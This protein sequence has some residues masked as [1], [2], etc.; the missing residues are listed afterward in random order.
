MEKYEFTSNES[1]LLFDFVNQCLS[2]MQ[3]DPVT[4]A[5]VLTDFIRFFLKKSDLDI[6]RSLYI[7]L[8]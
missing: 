7:K 2:S 3:V 1:S 8:D 6:L 4:G 5:Q